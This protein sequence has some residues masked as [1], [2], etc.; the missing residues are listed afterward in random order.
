MVSSNSI[1]SSVMLLNYFKKTQENGH[2]AVCMCLY[3]C[4]KDSCWFEWW[5]NV[6]EFSMGSSYFKRCSYVS[7]LTFI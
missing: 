3:V 2:L 6:C 1:M 5:T 4:Q 7:S